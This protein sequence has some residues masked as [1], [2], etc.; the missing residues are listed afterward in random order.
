MGKRL[1]RIFQKDIPSRISELKN[2]KLNLVLKNN[3]TI[4]GVLCKFENSII[5]VENGMGDKH[6][7]PLPE[8]IEIVYDKE[9][10]F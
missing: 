8:V 7:I 2:V 6:L 3:T 4:F 1:I 9:A 5:H 10:A